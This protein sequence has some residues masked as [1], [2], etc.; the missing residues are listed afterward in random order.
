MPAKR[1]ASVFEQYAHEYD[2]ITNAKQREQYHQKEVDALIERFSPTRVLD[3][4]CASGLTAM[5]FARRG[6]AAVGL[7]RSQRMIEVA[8]GKFGDT[9]LPLEFRRGEFERLSKKLHDSFDLVVCLANSVSGVTT[10]AG[11][12]KTLKNFRAILK[13]GGHLV[14]Q[15]LNY[16]AVKEGALFPIRATENDGIVYQRFSERRGSRVC[17]YVTRLDLNR[18]L[19]DYEV[20]R[21]EFDNYDVDTINRLVTQTGFTEV[22]KFGDLYMKK[23]FGRSSPAAGSLR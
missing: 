5:L 15:M 21:H 2:L 10:L 20:F 4:G 23:R 9:D 14:V 8:R 19:L 11:L 22:R 18:K 7:D 12:R 1:S 16:A 3:A 6:V 13:P 17:V